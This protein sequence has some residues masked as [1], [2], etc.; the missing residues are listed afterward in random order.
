MTPLVSILI[1]AHNAERWIAD[2]LRSALGQTWPRTEV[3]VVDSGST[4]N[5][6]GVARRFESSVVR[7]VSERNQGASGARNTAFELSRG[8]YIQW[9][10]A[11]DL[12]APDKIAA[13][14]EAVNGA[15]NRVLLCSAWGTFLYRPGKA[16]FAPTLLWTDLTPLEW[17]HRRMRE[18]LHMQTAT[19]LVSRELTEA[20]GPWDVRLSLDDDGEYFCRVICASESIR[21]VPDAKVFYRNAAFQR[22]STIDRSNEKLASQF[23]S[24]KLQ[25]QH[26]LS[27]DDSDET[28]AACLK[29]LQIWLFCFYDFR[30]DLA[31][32]LE[33]LALRLGGRLE[34][35]QL[36]KKYRW[37]QR[38]A[39]RRAA[40]RAQDLLPR[41]KWRLVGFWD[42]VLSGFE[43][44]S[45]GAD[46]T[47]AKTHSLS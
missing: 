2:T 21:F 5:T 42:F 24:I 10:D 13:Q 43:R 29:F 9:L 19:W 39:G 3:I 38:L 12:L 41:T 11:D 37:I 40:R 17:F 34:V 26:V 27:L 8:D 36:R 4:D 20:A 30:K 44:A 6:L 31:N 15:S 32:N 45:F 28:R 35:P 47:P 1:P 46:A 22:L 18:N 25:I 16:R 14:M 23:L 33:Q 7:V